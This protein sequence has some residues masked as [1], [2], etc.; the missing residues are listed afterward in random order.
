MNRPG[1]Q[2]KR[3]CQVNKLFLVG[4]GIHSM[5]V[6]YIPSTKQQSDFLCLKRVDKLKPLY[7]P[8][9]GRNGIQILLKDF[10]YLID[11]LRNKYLYCC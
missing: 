1:S 4:H 8:L 9:T 3:L 6:Q 5:D 7:C 2:Y 10:F 11:I